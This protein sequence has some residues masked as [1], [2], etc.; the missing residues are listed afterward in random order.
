MKIL[1]DECLPRRLKQ[2][3]IGHTVF[4][5]PE[6]GWAGTKNGALLRLAATAFDVFVTLDKNLEYQ[7]NLK[8]APIAVIVLVAPDSKI[9]TL[10]PLIPKVLD[11]LAKTQLKPGEP[12]A[13]SAL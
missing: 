13:V 7:Q 6:R 2:S 4:T 11:I 8:A 3:L 12:I 10:K 5:V 1:L 9:E